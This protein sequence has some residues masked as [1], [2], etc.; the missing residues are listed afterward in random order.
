MV[1]S[2]SIYIDANGITSFFLWLSN[3]PLS[4]C[5]TPSLSIHHVNG[6]IL[7]IV[8]SAAITIE[9]HISFQIIVLSGKFSGVGL[10]DHMVVLFS[11]F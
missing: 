2:S 7:A 1:I 9:V 3:I 8:N 6:H 4:I 10:L 5:T 11:A